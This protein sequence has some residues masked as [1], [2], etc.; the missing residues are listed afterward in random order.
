MFLLRSIRSMT[1]L[2]NQKRKDII[3]GEFFC[4][5]S[6]C[7]RHLTSFISLVSAHCPR[8]N[9]AGIAAADLRAYN[10]IL[11]QRLEDL[12]TKLDRTCSFLEKYHLLETFCQE[13]GDQ[14]YD[15]MGDD[16]LPFFCADC[17]ALLPIESIDLNNYD[18]ICKDCEA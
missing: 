3:M 4:T 7:S 13:N 12:Q 5:N 16:T 14:W 17:S 10:V 18:N 15:E 1:K 2:F 11:T 8:C 9:E 6:E